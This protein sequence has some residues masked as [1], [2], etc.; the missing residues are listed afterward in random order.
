MTDPA[1]H[2]FTALDRAGYRLTD[3]R[4]AVAELIA[5][6][7]GHFTAADLLDEA[8]ARRMAVGRATVFRALELFASLGTLERLDLP[9][10]DHA[11]V[12]CEPS[13]H[14]HIVCSGCGRT[15]GID[16]AGIG[17]LLAEIGERTGFTVDEHR[18]ELYGTCG[19]CR[20]TG[21]DAD[22]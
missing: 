3:P 7:A 12:A 20:H 4:R 19:E 18:L 14:H 21:S 15:A 8:H 6:R 2:L 16:D 13:H 9:G 10:G 22:A 1:D 5:S 17:T 11:Y